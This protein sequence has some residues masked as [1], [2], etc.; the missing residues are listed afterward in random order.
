MRLRRLP[1]TAVE[2]GRLA[3]ALN[4]VFADGPL[5]RETRRA[6]RGEEVPARWGQLW[7]RLV[8]RE[9]K[10]RQG[11]ASM[12]F[13]LGRGPQQQEAAFQAGRSRAHFRESAHS[14]VDDYGPLAV[15]V[16]MVEAGRLVVIPSLEAEAVALGFV[17]GAGWRRSDPS[18]VEVED[19][20]LV[21]GKAVE[22]WLVSR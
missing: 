2:A 9:A 7:T 20:P 13:D 6:R 3:R 18:H 21:A 10:L 8:E 4:E 5:A 22:A 17:S 15:D 1:R 12:V 14:W 11:S 16:Y 19:W